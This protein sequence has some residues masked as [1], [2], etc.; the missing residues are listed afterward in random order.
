[1]NGNKNK[2]IPTNRFLLPLLFIFFSIMLEV[3][4]FLWLG[5]K[6][7]GG[8]LQLYPTQWLFNIGGTIALAGIIF[9]ASKT[10]LSLTFFYLFLGVQLGI[11]I[12]NANIFY[13]FGDIFSLDYLTLAGE[14]TEAIKL[15]FIDFGS[16][17]L[18]VGLYTVIVAVSVL[19]VKKNKTTFKIK[20]VSNWIFALAIL[21]LCESCGVSLFALQQKMVE[22]TTAS[23]IESNESYLWDS[24]QFKLDAYREF[25]Y[26]GFYVKNIYNHIKGPDDLTQEESD[27][28]VQFIQEGETH[29]EQLDNRLANDNLIVILCESHEWFAYDPYN[30][31]FIWNLLTQDEKEGEMDVDAT[32]FTKYYA[33]N[34]TNVSEGIVM[35][36]SMTQESNLQT[37]V[38]KYGYDYKYTLPRLFEKAHEGERVETNY[39]HASWGDT[40]ERDRDYSEEGYG[41]KNLYFMDKITQQKK[42]DSFGDWTSDYQFTEEFADQMVPSKEQCDKFLSFYATIS[43]HGPY[44]SY[45]PR[46]EEYYNIFDENYE[47]FSDWFSFEHPELNIANEDYY[48]FRRYK[49][50]AIDFDKTVQKI[51]EELQ[52]KDRLEETTVVMFA[53]HDCYYENLAVHL[54]GIDKREYSNTETQRVPLIIYNS[55]LQPGEK[56]MFCNTYDIYP[57][58][59]ELHGLEYN[60]NLIQGYNLFNE[61]EIQNSFFASFLGGM[62]NDNFYSKN[63]ALMI[64]LKET[65]TDE[66]IKIFKDHAERFF[67]RQGTLEKIYLHN[68]AK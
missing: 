52:E 39:F 32:Y 47:E 6:T 45:N 4:N 57:A 40:Y 28:L 58:I 31:P 18:Y 17:A 22:E 1:M 56:D 42:S 46:Y 11:N 34:K 66:D 20:A 50:S 38:S 36:G 8:G 67:S 63:I 44:D 3:V 7:N 14:A 33:D 55:K 13:V 15:E 59:C 16:I 19:L 48:A 21:I 2:S 54:K 23:T 64:P 61:D 53:D 62:F 30:T 51:F 9:I 25:G 43:T 41:F 60:K 35:A 65:Y 27:Q 12:V 49:A 5:F 10:W 24:F 37:L 29:K 68:L 26:Y